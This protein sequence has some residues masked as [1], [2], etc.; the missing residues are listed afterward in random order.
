M[1]IVRAG[2]N[3]SQKG[4]GEQFTGSV[5]RDFLVNSEAPGRLTM[6][7][8]TF[9]VG[10]R[11]VWHTHPLGQILF[12]VAGRGWVQC[13]GGAIEEMRPGDTVWIPAEVKHWHGASADNG[14]THIAITEAP[15]G[16]AVEWMEPVTD[17]QYR[18]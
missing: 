1:K 13:W 14:V 5:R 6:G 11:T 16:N 17:D 15:D 4:P 8:N 7:M 2:S 18:L 9:D 10:A 3:A 12:I